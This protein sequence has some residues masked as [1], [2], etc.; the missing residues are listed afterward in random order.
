MAAVG[1][2]EVGVFMAA[3]VAGDSM[4]E[5]AAD[6]AEAFTAVTD[7][8]AEASAAVVFAAAMVGSTTAAVA[9]DGGVVGAV[10]DGVGVTEIGMIGAGA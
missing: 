7:S 1:M 4:V 5:G 2:A 6:S 9:V 8:M 10:A 3:V